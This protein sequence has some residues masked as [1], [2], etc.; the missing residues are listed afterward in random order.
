MKFTS[1]S[2]ISRQETV[3]SIMAAKPLNKIFGQPT[4]KN[5]NIMTE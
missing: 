4:T 2:D 3:L 5:M 1:L